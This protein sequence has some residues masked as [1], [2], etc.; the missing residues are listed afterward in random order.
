[1][2]SHIGQVTGSGVRGVR[3]LLTGIA[4]L[5]SVF[6][7]KISSAVGRG[8]VVPGRWLPAVEAGRDWGVAWAGRV[9]PD[10]AAERGGF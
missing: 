9:A 7:S 8:L 5:T 2:V 4:W 10:A 3:E 6:S 1:M